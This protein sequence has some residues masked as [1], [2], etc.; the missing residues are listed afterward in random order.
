MPREALIRVAGAEVAEA[1]EEPV[2]RRGVG[3]HRLGEGPFDRLEGPPDQVPL[4][5]RRQAAELPVDRDDPPGVDPLGVLVVE[6][7]VVRVLEHDVPAVAVERGPAEHDGAA[8]LGEH[9]LQ[10]LVRRESP[11]DSH[12]IPFCYHNLGLRIE[13]DLDAGRP[14]HVPQHSG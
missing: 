2:A 9:A 10:S 12:N 4:H 5:P 14:V 8:P 7:L 1:V 3:G 6:R 11:R 13:A